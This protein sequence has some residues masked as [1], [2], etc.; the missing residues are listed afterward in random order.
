MSSLR[1][2]VPSST[3]MI[4]MTVSAI[5]TSRRGSLAALALVLGA[6]CITL[7]APLEERRR[8]VVSGS[9][10]AGAEG[11]G[12]Q[13]GG[14]TGAGGG[15]ASD[16]LPICPSG[17]T[18]PDCARNVAIVPGESQTCALA[19]DGFVRCWG[20][21]IDGQLGDPAQP[22]AS[23]LPPVLV[24]QLSQVD[25]IDCGFRHSCALSE[26]KAYCW[27]SNA[28]GQLG[29]GDTANRDLPTALP[30]DDVVAVSTRRDTTCVLTGDDR[31]F[32]AGKR[33]NGQPWDGILS[34]QSLIAVSGLDD[35][36]PIGRLEVGQVT[37]CVVRED[38]LAMRCWGDNG[39]G[40]VGD[41]TTEDRPEP[42]DVTDAL[43]TPVV[44][45]STGAGWTCT[46]AAPA[47][48]TALQ[49]W[50]NF[51]ELFGQIFAEP[52]QLP[53]VSGT[54][55]A[56]VGV[57]WSHLC[58]LGV[59]GDVRCL[60]RSSFHELGPSV[61]LNQSSS[62]PVSV[63]GDAAQLGV[64]WQHNCAISTSGEVLCWGRNYLGQ[65]VPGDERPEI[66]IPTA[67]PF[68]MD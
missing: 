55:V 34:S 10:G 66:P 53:T 51:S 25:A 59:M 4:E 48:D 68:S 62:V 3:F 27:G 63:L 57:G 26:G 31:V 15:A 45:L 18:G 19:S 52:T 23:H 37:T 49:C 8:A 61:P 42:V 6:G 65:S 44:A 50:G 33:H 40:Y 36:G 56:D 9:G 20:D 60:G 35:F 7:P 5:T 16:A 24:A 30:V 32:C 54:G 14:D 2:E 41:G 29:L 43:L 21:N 39:K 12:A 1:Y 17:V 58:S 64:G 11:G 67:V 28:F 38:G 47:S 13:G 22:K 46:V